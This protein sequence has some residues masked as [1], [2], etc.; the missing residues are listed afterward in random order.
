MAGRGGID[1]APAEERKRGPRHPNN[2]NA[3]T[4]PVL[5]KARPTASDADLMGFL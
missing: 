5:A 3:T 2:S 1:E 4:G